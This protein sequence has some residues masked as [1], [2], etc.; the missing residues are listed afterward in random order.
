MHHLRLY[1]NLHRA[2]VLLQTF[3]PHTLLPALSHQGL[4]IFEMM[5]VVMGPLI[6]CMPYH[7]CMPGLYQYHSRHDVLA[8]LQAL[9]GLCRSS[10]RRCLIVQPLLGHFQMGEHVTVLMLP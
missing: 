10:P 5:T 9:P 6:T 1:S 2:A 7:V 4:L 3:T 8:G